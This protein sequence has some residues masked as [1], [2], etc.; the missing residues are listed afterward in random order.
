[1]AAS[2]ALAATFARL[3]RSNPHQL[4]STGKEEAIETLKKRVDSGGMVMV[5][6]DIYLRYPLWN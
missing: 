4:Q 6:Q 3:T 1:M 2:Q 5:D